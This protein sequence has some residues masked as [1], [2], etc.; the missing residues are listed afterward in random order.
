MA[1]CGMMVEGNVV[2]FACDL[3][4]NHDG[5]HRA[6]ENSRSVRERDRWEAEK[7][8]AIEGTATL[9]TF[10]GP[11]QTTAERYTENPTPVPQTRQQREEQRRLRVTEMA[12]DR[13]EIEADLQAPPP[14]AAGLA[15][16]DE[17]PDVPAEF[18]RPVVVTSGADG[19]QFRQATSAEAKV[20]GMT[21]PGP[22]Q[23]VAAQQ[24][25]ESTFVHD[26]NWDNDAIA[27]EKVSG[28]TEQEMDDIVWGRGGPHRVNIPGVT[29]PLTG[30][31]NLEP[32]KQREG[33]QPLPIPTQGEYV[34]D[35]IIDKIERLRPQIGDEQADLLIAQMEESKRVGTQRYGT[36]LQT[37]NGRDCLQD[38]IDESRDLNVYLNSMQQAREAQREDL[39]EVV[40][41]ALHQDL[42]ANFG[43][44]V[45][46]IVVDEAARGF[47]EVAVDAILKATGGIGT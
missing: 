31:A 42:A 12:G 14:D 37:F 16:T 17:E 5:P 27:A 32:T 38:A 7:Q 13:P 28:L 30:I 2:S 4:S 41:K 19:T 18:E 24:I 45:E 9:A 15:E 34:Q 8:A 35:R 21:E 20:A 25:K 22:N 26:T 11:A 46:G 36:P 43:P 3:P 40:A 33:D 1:Q 23:R 6:V 29:E 44:E 39:I 10:Q 47:A